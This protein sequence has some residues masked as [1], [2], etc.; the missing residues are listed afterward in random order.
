MATLIHRCGYTILNRPEGYKGQW[1]IF[2]KNGTRARDEKGKV[3]PIQD[4]VEHALS[5]CYIITINKK[6]GDIAR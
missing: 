3:I 4:S 5:R 6:V 1:Y 2:N